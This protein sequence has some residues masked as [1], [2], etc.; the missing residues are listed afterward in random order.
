DLDA[1]LAAITPETRVVY[2]A[3]PNNPTGTMFYAEALDRLVEQVPQDVIIALDEAYSDYAE[4]YTRRS[5]KVYSRSIEYVREGRENVIVLRTFS[6]AHG[7]AGLRVGY[8]IG[9][10]QMLRY[11]GQVRTAFSVS[12]VAEAAAGAALRDEAHIRLS[13]ERNAEGVAY[14]APRL[15]DLGFRVVPT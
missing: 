14:L 8:G 1:I 9:D 12:G 7:L 2:I 4:F 13:L 15:Q 5:G 10:P 11:F 3:N 6:K